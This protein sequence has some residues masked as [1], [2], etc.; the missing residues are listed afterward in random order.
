MYKFHK[1]YDTA[2]DEVKTARNCIYPNDGFVHQLKS[3][4]KVLENR[5]E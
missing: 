5:E 2:K 4:W 3:Y 1:N